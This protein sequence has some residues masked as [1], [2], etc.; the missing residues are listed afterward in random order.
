[1]QTTHLF[2]RAKLQVFTKFLLLGLLA[3]KVDKELIHI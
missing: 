2:K 1:M 3:E